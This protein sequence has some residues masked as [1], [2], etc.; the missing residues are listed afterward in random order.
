MWAKAREGGTAVWLRVHSLAPACLL[1]SAWH[2]RLPLGSTCPSPV[3]D[4][5]PQENTPPLF[6]PRNPQ[7]LAQGLVH[8]EPIAIPC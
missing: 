2:L 8:D 3:P 4:R 6:S 7:G 5:H 1:S